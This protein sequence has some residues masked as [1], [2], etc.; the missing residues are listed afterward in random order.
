MLTNECDYGILILGDNMKYISRT[1]EDKL[2]S[3][4]DNYQVIMITGPRQ[5]GKSTLL[6]YISRKYNKKID[7]VTL[8]DLILR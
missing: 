7:R 6:S 8:D 5:V 1:I 3:M 2:I 4:I